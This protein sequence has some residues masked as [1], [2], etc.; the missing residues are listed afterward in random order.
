MSGKDGQDTN[1]DQGSGNPIGKKGYTGN[2]GGQPKWLKEFREK[3]KGL[4]P[5]TEAV[6]RKVL[7]RFTDTADLQR[8]MDDP[9]ASDEAKLGAEKAIA[10]RGDQA[11]RMTG[12]IW[13]YILTKPTTRV[14]VEGRLENPLSG[15]STEQL[16]QLAGKKPEGE[17]K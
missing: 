7:G 17:S 15:L 14:R 8:I 3:L 16:L 5:D 9:T 6:A 13:P 2:P 1:T 4:A 10:T 11:I 12:E